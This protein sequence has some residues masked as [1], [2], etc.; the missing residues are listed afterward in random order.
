MDSGSSVLKICTVGDNV[1][2]YLP[3]VTVLFRMAKDRLQSAPPFS[4]VGVDTFGQ[5]IITQ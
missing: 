3:Q 5:V 2:R 4:Y 1:L